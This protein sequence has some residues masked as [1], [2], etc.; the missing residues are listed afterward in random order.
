MTLCAVWRRNHQIQIATDSRLS[1]NGAGADVCVKLMPL[2][3]RL[4]HATKAGEERP[5][6]AHSRVLGVATVGSLTTTYVVKEL[7]EAVLSNLQFAE[8]LTDISMAVIANVCARVMRSTSRE[9][10]AA[11]FDKGLGQIVLL[12]H[13]LAKEMPRVFL[14][15]VTTGDIGVDVAVEEI[16]VEDGM[17]F[18]GSGALAAEQHINRSTDVYPY[19]VVRAVARDSSVPSVGGNVQFGVLDGPDFRVMGIRDFKKNDVLKEIYVGFYIAGLEIYGGSSLLGD[20]GFAFAR[21][22]LSPYEHEIIDLMDSG[23]NLVETR[24]HW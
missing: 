12:G 13:C 6:I 10:C 17:R 5:Q 18:F 23:Y 21:S 1:V 7:L 2:T 15:T 8:G 3:L 14:L 4:C 24:A 16:L 11:I 22:F 19:Q 9:I 20:L